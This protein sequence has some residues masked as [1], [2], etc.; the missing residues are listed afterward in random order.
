MSSFG[1]Y[2]ARP[3]RCRLPAACGAECGDG[4]TS[5]WL[6]CGGR[7]SPRGSL[8]GEVL[9]HRGRGQWLADRGERLG[10]L[11]PPDGVAGQPLAA[12]PGVDLNDV[13]DG[14]F[15]GQFE[16]VAWRGGWAILDERVEP[17]RGCHR[18]GSALTS[19]GWSVW[20]QRL[21][22]RLR[23]E[24][25]LGSARSTGTRCSWVRSPPGVHP[26]RAEVDIFAGL[27][28]TGRRGV[29]E[30][31][32]FRRQDAALTESHTCRRRGNVRSAAEPDTPPTIKTERGERGSRQIRILDRGP[33]SN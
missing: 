6:V 32:R 20:L 4:A 29:L 1:W 18:G 8:V 24:P 10:D 12:G 13:P 27:C 17:R 16:H 30:D 3:R 25:L 21:I 9:V 15:P 28:A 7:R 33:W 23:F 22:R 26:V 14:Q 11:P 19:Q 2:T 5:R 31:H